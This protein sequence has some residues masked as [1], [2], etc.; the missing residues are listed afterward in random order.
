MAIAEAMRL[1]TAGTKALQC[2]LHHYALAGLSLDGLSNEFQKRFCN[3]CP[4]KKSRPAEW[5]LK[6]PD[7]SRPADMPDKR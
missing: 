3:A 6:A 2:A 7:D 1:P 5:K 4:D